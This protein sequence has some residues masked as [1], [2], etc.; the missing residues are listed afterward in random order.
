MDLAVKQS[1][2][3]AVVGDVH[4][5]WEPEDEVALKHLGVDIVLFVGDFGNEAIEVVEAIATLDLPK[6]VVFGNHDAWYS[7]TD[8]GRKHCPYDPEVENRV[9]RQIELLG[10]D[11]VGYG[12]RDF[13]TWGITVVGTR[14]FSWGGPKWGNHKFYRKWFG[15]EGFQDSTQR[16]LEAVQEAAYDNLIFLGHNGPKGLGDMPEA[17][18]GKDWKP[19]GGDYGDPDF[20]DAITQARM[21]GKTI[22]LVTFGHMHHT[23]RHTKTQL[24]QCVHVSPEE[25]LYLNAARVKRIEEIENQ[26]RRNFS[27]ISLQNGVVSEAQLV[28]VGHDL[29]IVETKLL[30]Q[31]SQSIVATASML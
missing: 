24:R 7:M 26:K 27:I 9:Q 14:P 13:P 12:K 11:H 17:P 21:L 22:S 31:R 4:N 20:A 25:T 19:I 6:A 2:K 29:S 1:C 28:W 3:I 5:Q 15:V 18:C 30:Y 8:W 16:I 23:L 10:E